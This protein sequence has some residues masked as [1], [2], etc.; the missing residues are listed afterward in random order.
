MMFQSWAG[1]LVIPFTS[2]HRL[3]SKREI[4]TRCEALHSKI[5]KAGQKWI[6]AIQFS[7]IRICPDM[8][9]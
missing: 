3:Y 4:P 6:V 1:L 8:K 7:I 5:S 2:K 9:A